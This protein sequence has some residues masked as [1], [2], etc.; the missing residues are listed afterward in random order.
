MTFRSRFARPSDFPKVLALLQQDRPL[1]ENDTWKILPTLIPDLIERGRLTC[2]VV[3][4]SECNRPAFLGLTAWVDL[5][6]LGKITA[7]RPGLFRNALFQAEASRKY[8]F[9]PAKSIPAVNSAG[10]LSL[11]HLAGC[12]DEKDFTQQ[13][14]YEIHRMAFE[15]FMTLH[16]GYRVAEFWQ[17]NWLPE[18]SLHATTM[19]ME[20]HWSVPLAEGKSA[21]LFRFDRE[22]AHRRPGAQLAYLMKYPP[23]RL[24]F[25]HPQ[26]RLL[27]LALL[28]YS[29]A[30]AAQELSVTVEAIRKRWR[31][32]HAR[33]DFGDGK[34]QRRA[35]LAYL[36]QH[37]E[38]LRPWAP[39]TAPAATSLSAAD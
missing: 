20:E 23:P 33:H 18:A 3:E 16:A 25:T 31:A 37:M 32:I 7:G 21:R 11:V 10:T 8:V 17:E 39:A 13:R 1:F 2:G 38:E 6:R 19:G 24:G 28:D 34:D 15:F 9:L 4:D 35:L 26:Q 30:A 14:G 5:A 27:Q 36:R 22:M 12:P 29:D